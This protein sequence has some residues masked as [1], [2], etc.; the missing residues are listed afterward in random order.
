M[1]ST[2]DKTGAV[3]SKEMPNSEV[4]AFRASHDVLGVYPRGP[5]RSLVAYLVKLDPPSKPR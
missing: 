4:E 5:D 1:K 3:R 2:P